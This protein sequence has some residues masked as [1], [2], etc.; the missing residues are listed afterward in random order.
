MLFMNLKEISHSPFLRFLLVGSIS[1][2]INYTIF[3]LCLS[4]IN[5]N[6]SISFII[7][8]LSGLATG[9]PLNRAWSFKVE[10]ASHMMI[11]KYIV[12]YLLSLIF[13]SILLIILVEYIYI[14]ASISNI[15]VIFFTTFF[16]F[17]ALKLFVFQSTS[18]FTIG[19]AGDSGTGKST[20]ATTLNKILRNKTLIITGDSFHRYDRKSAKWN[21]ITHL[22]PEANFI[23]KM[24]N[25]VCVVK[26]NNFKFIRKYCHKNG[27]FRGKKL[28]FPKKVVI[29]EGLHSLY[30]K[31]KNDI[32]DLKI[33]IDLE[34]DIK[35]A[36]KVERDI[37][38]RRHELNKVLSVIARR[39]DDFAKYILPQKLNSH[40][41]LYETGDNILIEIT[42]KSIDCS[43]LNLIISFINNSSIEYLEERIVINLP[44]KIDNL[45]FKEIKSFLQKQ[46]VCLNFRF[47]PTHYGFVVLIYY[48]LSCMHNDNTRS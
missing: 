34:Q 3:Y 17:I 19:I 44:V 4:L 2:I 24:Y 37:N 16:N 45:E 36:R 41:N 25:T 28:L 18:P 31:K 35:K 1:T 6:Y 23:D 5:I 43:G 33:F 9:Y 39:K 32:Y 11:L 26:G 21:S 47:L 7:G 29:C 46:Y 40:I 48:I 20:I 30:D 13:G 10:R 8:F 15:L 12:V 27:L 38:Q 14:P 42:N 22:N